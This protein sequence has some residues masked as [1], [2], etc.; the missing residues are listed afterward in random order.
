MRRFLVGLVLSGAAA[1]AVAA[2]PQLPHKAPADARAYIIGPADGAT[3]GRD[4]KVRFGLSGMGIAPAGVE[5]EY[6]G[7]HHLLIDVAALPAAGKPIPN[8]ERHKHF[9]GGQTETVL[10]LPPGTHTLQLEL[11]DANHVP[12]D[13]PIVSKRITIHVQ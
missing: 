7:H 3:V 9:G 8:D 1:F 10:H 4:V 13:P 5:K 6:T 12:F 11:G 2:S